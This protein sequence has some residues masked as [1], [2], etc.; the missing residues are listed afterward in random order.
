M[1]GGYILLYPRARVITLVFI[2]FFFTI[3]ELPAF[4][5]LGVWFILDGVAGAVNAPGSEGVAYFAHIGGFVFGLRRSAPSRDAAPRRAAAPPPGS[6]ERPRMRTAV[7]AIAL[8]FI[9]GFAFLTVAAA[10]EQGVTAATVLSV[11]ILV[12][13]AVGIVG[14]LRNP[15]GQ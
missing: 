10:F 9:A 1:L 5:L 11:F 3:V 14:A 8:V 15:P 4:V 13:L 6:H 2:V 7:L 12:L